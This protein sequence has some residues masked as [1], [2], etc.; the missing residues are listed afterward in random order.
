MMHP[1]AADRTWLGELCVFVVTVSLAGLANLVMATVVQEPQWWMTMIS[2]GTLFVG[3]QWAAKRYAW[4]VALFRK[5]HLVAVPDIGGRWSGHISS[6]HSGFV[7]RQPI[8]I[9]I[10]Q[11]WSNLSVALDTRASRSWSTS[12]I[13]RTNDLPRA[14]LTYTYINEPKPTADTAMHTHRGTATLQLVGDE[15][16]GEYYT[17]RDRGAFGK[18]VVQRMK[19]HEHVRSRWHLRLTT[20]HDNG[21]NCS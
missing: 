2:F 19:S 13:L 21:D 9:Q 3:V 18:I 8:T 4:R 11:R 10:V 12:A 20:K 1:Y 14:E 16:I 17:G 5:L 7:E 15:L 6:S